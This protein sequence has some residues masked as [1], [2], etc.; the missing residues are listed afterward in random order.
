MKKVWSSIIL[1][2]LISLVSIR[3]YLPTYLKDYVNHE[4][5]NLSGY[6][7]SVKGVGISLYRG[8]YQFNAFKLFKVD[9]EE[10]YPLFNAENIDISL[11]WGALFEGKIVAEVYL[12]DFYVDIDAGPRDEV[13]SVDNIE[14]IK[15]TDES[16][17]QETLRALIPIKINVIDLKEGEVIIAKGDKANNVIFS[18]ESLKGR[19]T[20][21]RNR[22]E[23]KP[24]KVNIESKVFRDGDLKINGEMNILSKKPSYDF[25]ASIENIP[26]VNV[27][28]FARKFAFLDFE[29]GNL[30]I[31]SEV[32]TT[33]TKIEGYIKPIIKSLEV[34]A[35]EEEKGFINTIW[36]G[37]ASVMLSIVENDNKDQVATVIPFEG[38]RDNP[39]AETFQ[40]ILNLL[41]N[42]FI[43]AYEKGFLK[44]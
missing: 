15:K 18:F 31:Y 4:L 16:M 34:F 32:K 33:K 35:L 8:A 36:Q 21:L 22:G 6:S 11:H 24:S 10:E 29:G 9:K 12:T 7:G 44:K 20:N 37:L 5:S 41:S 43:E 42:A 17:W 13:N 39:D 38:K 14:D 28:Y 19:V 25:K 26:L 40:S 3:L 30:N 1:V 2:I 27:N 23:S